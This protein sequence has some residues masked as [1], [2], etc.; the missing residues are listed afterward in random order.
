MKKF[1]KDWERI[2]WGKVDEEVHVN[3]YPCR[4]D[5]K[6]EYEINGRF[7]FEIYKNYKCVENWMK[8]HGF[9]P[10]GEI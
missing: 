7:I 4:N 10:K 5:M 1:V 2:T 6:G 8:K 3:F 9:T